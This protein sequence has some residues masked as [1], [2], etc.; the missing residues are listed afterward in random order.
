VS[1]DFA[2]DFADE[3]LNKSMSMPG[4]APDAGAAPPAAFGAPQ[5]W[6]TRGPTAPVLPASGI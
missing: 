2:H 5:S 4:A 3:S 6:L 1:T